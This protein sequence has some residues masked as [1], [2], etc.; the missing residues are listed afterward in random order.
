MAKTTGESV[1]RV[2]QQ[3]AKAPIEEQVKSELIGFLGL[4]AGIQSSS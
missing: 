4:L 1:A 2:G 3:I